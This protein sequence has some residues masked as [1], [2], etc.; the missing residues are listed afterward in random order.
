MIICFVFFWQINQRTGASVIPKVHKCRVTSTIYTKGGVNQMWILK[1]SKDP[2]EH[3]QTM[4]LS[5]YNSI[6]NNFS[7]HL[8]TPTVKVDIYVFI[9]LGLSLESVYEDLLDNICPL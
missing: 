9:V 4:T 3:I 1:N 6:K 7:T 5:S 2:F 8:F